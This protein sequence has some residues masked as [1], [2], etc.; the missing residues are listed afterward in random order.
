MG[1]LMRVFITSD[2][3]I[4]ALGFTTAENFAAITAYRSGI[5]LAA[6]THISATPIM[7]A[8]IE[9]TTLEERAKALTDGDKYSPVEQLLI[10]SI[11]DTLQQQRLARPEGSTALIL[12]TTKGNVAAL[13]GR[14]DIPDEAFLSH[15]ARRVADYFGIAATDTYLISN[16][17]ISGV[18][19]LIMAARLIDEGQYNKAI[20]A[21]CDVL[22]PFIT[23]GFLSFKSISPQ[24][25]RPYD[26]A[27]NGLNLGEA[28]G[29]V[30]LTSEYTPGS[31]AITGGSIT[32][33]ANHI[34]GPSRTGD[35]LFYAIR[36]AMDEAGV[37]PEEVDFV[38]AHGTATAYNDEMESKA[39]HLAGVQHVPV[40]SLKPYFG[41]TLGASGVI[42][43]II[44]AHAMQQDM[45]PATLHF[46]QLGVPCPIVVEATHRTGVRT[47]VC[48]KT[49]SG[50]GGCNAAIVLQK[51][52]SANRPRPQLAPIHAIAHCRI[53]GGEIVLDGQ[54]LFSCDPDTPFATFI[55]EAYKAIDGNNMKFYKMSDLGKTAYI[56][57]EVLLQKTPTFVPTEA[58]I[59]LANR[60]ASLDTDRRHQDIIDNE[61]E[62]AAAPAVFVY[63]LPNVAAGEVCIRHK[64]QGENTF[65]IGDTY[66]PDRLER[67]ARSAMSRDGLQYCIVGWCDFLQGRY[68]ADLKLFTTK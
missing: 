31:I 40:N 28:C 39:I 33:D 4:S 59:I 42:E 34:S 54:T 15:T 57:T 45:I 6:D 43:S 12:S 58:G 20:V 32:N 1:Y 19:A 66:Q 8:T 18:S 7:A 16:A 2:N 9:R 30:L 56:A 37:T 5:A 17:C 44:C 24:C 49:A 48:V 36:H 65:F 22:S 64:I 10:L 38:N 52:A 55:R 14:S 62:A 60:S 27:R 29:S 26:A 21:G 68:L 50:F 3:I 35:G 23:S 13:G 47:D 41:H 11:T 46:E 51:N 53:A 63:T 67:Y 61:G 25:C